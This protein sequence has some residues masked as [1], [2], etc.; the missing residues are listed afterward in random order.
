M[1][2]SCIIVFINTSYI[3]YCIILLVYRTIGYLVYTVPALNVY[4][5]HTMSVYYWPDCTQQFP[6]GAGVRTKALPG[7]A[8]QSTFESR[9]QTLRFGK[10]SVEPR[11]LPIDGI[12][13]GLSWCI[14]VSAFIFPFPDEAMPILEDY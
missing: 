11:S 7:G 14:S 1:S 3:G 6:H 10:N 12:F 9:Y 4:T 2:I 5:W 13:S 8:P